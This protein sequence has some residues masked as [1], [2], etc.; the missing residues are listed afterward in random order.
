MTARR[1]AICCGEGLPSTRK[2]E[3]V[4]V[5]PLKRQQPRSGYV[6]PDTHLMGWHCEA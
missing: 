4:D 5:K 2:G 1:E 6:E 3:A